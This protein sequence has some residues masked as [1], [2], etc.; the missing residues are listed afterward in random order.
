[1]AAPLLGSS[2]FI[3]AGKAGS[4]KR[5]I[6]DLVGVGPKGRL[7]LL[8]AGDSV[9]DKASSFPELPTSPGGDHAGV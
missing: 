8:L 2:P 1:M 3:T 9:T 5:E 6:A 4:G 7:A